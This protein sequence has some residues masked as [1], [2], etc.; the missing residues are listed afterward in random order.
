MAVRTSCFH[1]FHVDCLLEW[2]FLEEEKQKE[3]RKA[4]PQK[5]PV[6]EALN[7]GLAQSV[8]HRE[9]KYLDL[10]NEL[11]MIEKQLAEYEGYL[12]K[13]NF[14]STDEAAFFT[15]KIMELKLN[16][17][18]KNFSISEELTELKR[19]EKE[20]EEALNEIKIRSSKEASKEIR[21]SIICPVCRTEIF[22]G[23]NKSSFS[24]L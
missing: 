10:K 12:Q 3:K 18:M 16:K 9:K 24:S 13:G 17:K 4:K 20:L 14:V 21:R 6:A 2:W 8:K 1:T 7:A 15:K 23:K 5:N 22:L 11:Y 19:K